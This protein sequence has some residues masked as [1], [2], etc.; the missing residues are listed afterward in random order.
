MSCA[1]A[2]GAY[3]TASG[4]SIGV[5]GFKDNLSNFW[6][7]RW[8]SSWDCNISGGSADISGSM[9]V[10][11]HYFENGNVQFEVS[12]LS[13]PPSPPPPS[14]RLPPPRFQNKSLVLSHG[15]PPS[16]SVPPSLSSSAPRK[17]R[18]SR[19]CRGTS[20][21][22]RVTLLLTCDAALNCACQPGRGVIQRT[23]PQA[24]QDQARIQ[25]AGDDFCVSLL[26]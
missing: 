11:V 19:A 5:S 12:A 8:S 20:S 1:G 10:L 13:P 18:W 26:L 4:V 23:S 3:S 25:L 6:S 9:K 15:R 24:A 7:G 14:S 21:R 22:C 17:K 2:A 16:T